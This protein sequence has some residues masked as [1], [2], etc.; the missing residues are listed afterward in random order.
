[1]FDS[2]APRYDL[3]NHLLSLGIDKLWRKKAVSLI[4]PYGPR[5][6]LDVA[7]GTADLAIEAATLNPDLVVGIDISP[8]MLDIGRRKVQRLGKSEMIELRQGASED[9]PLADHSFDAAMVA[10]GVRNFENLQAGLREM[11]RVLA[12]GA[13]LVVLEFSHPSRFPVKQLYEFYF[14][15]V[16]PRIGKAVSKHES[17]Y[18]YLPESVEEFPFGQDFL[19]EMR[20]AGFEDLSIRP[21]TFGIA[22]I[23]FGVR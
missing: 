1:M 18:E 22:S 21:V 16:V 12:E 6:I 15:H 23:Y 13:P 20:Q 2:I 11:H 17:A 7:T 19:R 3:L 10:F 9:L 5:R 14:K 8:E 4:A